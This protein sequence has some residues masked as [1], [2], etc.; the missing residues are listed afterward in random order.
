MYVERL[1]HWRKVAMKT[2]LS[3]VSAL[4][5]AGCASPFVDDSSP[6]HSE[7]QVHQSDATR[8]WSAESGRDVL[9]GGV[10]GRRFDVDEG[11]VLLVQSMPVGIN[12]RP[13]P[14]TRGDDRWMLIR[15]DER[16][17]EDF[18]QGRFL[19]TLGTFQSK[20][21]TRLGDAETEVGL[22]LVDSRDTRLWSDRVYR[23][24]GESYFEQLRHRHSPARY[25][26]TRSPGRESTLSRRGR[27]ALN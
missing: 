4:L 26:L 10:I 16:L 5:L 2:V 7:R 6:G 21:R 27:P 14:Y 11:T 17:P 15:H 1:V 12:G 22:A 24:Y 20:E 8:L 19:T 3:I 13:L 25:R 9:W 23:T 18:R